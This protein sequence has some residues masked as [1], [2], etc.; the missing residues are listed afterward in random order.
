MPSIFSCHKLFLI[1][2]HQRYNKI[3]NY[4]CP[5]LDSSGFP[6]GSHG[7]ESA[8]DVGELDMIP[9]LFLPGESHGQ[10]SLAGYSPWGCRELDTAERL[11]LTDSLRFLG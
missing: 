2:S 6:G 7:Q 3:T 1:F 9:G 11:T 8:C 5:G 4:L 10:R